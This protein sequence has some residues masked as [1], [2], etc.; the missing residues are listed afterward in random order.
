MVTPTG[1]CILKYFTS[2]KDMNE[3]NINISSIGYGAGDRDISGQPNALRVIIGEINEKE[4]GEKTAVI[5]ANIDDLIPLAYEVVF[6]KLFKAGALDVFLTNIQM[7][8]N[9]PALMLSVVCREAD[10]KMLSEVI[11]KET[12]T[13]GL[14]F[15]ST[16]RIKLEKEFKTVKTNYGKIRIKIGKLLGKI[17]SAS[18][19]YEDCREISL[20]KNIPFKSVYEGAKRAFKN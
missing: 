10:I 19:E 4:E 1:V 9:R 13:F 18:P 12:T 3:L 11:F 17:M 14:R 2:P 16:G 8:K 7:K 20:S 5:E 6:E 15:Y